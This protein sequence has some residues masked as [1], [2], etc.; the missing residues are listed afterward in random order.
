MNGFLLGLS[1]GPVQSFIAVA[2]K[3]RDLWFGS[4]VLSEISKAAACSLKQNGAS[5]IF[6]SPEREEMLSSG[7]EFCV[8]NKVLAEIPDSLNPQALT[9][10]ARE[11]AEECWR[12]F[13][14]EALKGGREQVVDRSIWDDQ[15]DDVI[16][17]YAAW[18]PANGRENYRKVRE[19]LDLVLAGRKALRDFLPAR[20]RAGIPKSS[21]DG[22]RESVIR[23]DLGGQ[24]T[25]LD[26]YSG[27]RPGEELDVVGFVK[28]FAPANVSGTDLR[29]PSVSRVAADTW[30]GSRMSDPRSRSVL[31]GIRRLCH[32]DFAPPISLRQYQDFPFEA[33]VL[34]PSR[35]DQMLKDPAL[36]AHWQPIR[37]IRSMLREELG[38]PGPYPYFAILVADGDRIGAALSSMG[39]PERHRQFSLALSKFALEART[40]VAQ[41]QGWMVYSGGDDV[42][43]FLPVETALATARGLREAFLK[44]TQQAVPQLGVTLSVGIAIGHHLEPL[45]DLLAWARQAGRDAKEDPNP[46]RERDGIALHIHT[47]GGRPVRWRDRWPDDP[48]T[49]LLH[50]RDFFVKGRLPDGMVYDIYDLYR[51]YSGWVGCEPARPQMEMDGRRVLKMKRAKGA[52]LPEDIID[53]IASRAGSPAD[54]GRLAFE[55]LVA[56]TLAVGFKQNGLPRKEG[57][58]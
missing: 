3:T 6:P 55:L 52:P 13:A 1:V 39:S 31:D 37:R 30:I 44:Y 21:L 23:R 4:H 10:Q 20:G 25:G 34:Y 9:A 40:I 5:L 8:A 15:V 47:R 56:R 35:L 48:D 22:A 14:E 43:A 12:N 19:R 28:R 57:P 29:F 49:R 42:L 26:R 11:A 58:R 53:S 51:T 45:A 18:V 54:I 24:I 46:A 36:E 7:S 41:N 32:P 16:E 38:G 27:L 33:D 17:F 50:W 2:R